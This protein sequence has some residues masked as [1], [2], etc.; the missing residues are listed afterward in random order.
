MLLKASFY[1]P[2]YCV[3]FA[4]PLVLPLWKCCDSLDG[5]QISWVLHNWVLKLG[6]AFAAIVVEWKLM[7]VESFKIIV[8]YCS[9][10]YKTRLMC[11][12]LNMVYWLI[13]L[14]P[15]NINLASNIGL[16]YQTMIYFFSSCSST[17]YIQN[18]FC[19]YSI[20]LH[21]LYNNCS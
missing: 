3:L 9:L 18:L 11:A 16:N 13:L 19:T 12:Y 1:V 17:Q 15:L 5:F 6:S 20:V 4:Q 2:L 21:N 8:W 14:F 10:P 7:R